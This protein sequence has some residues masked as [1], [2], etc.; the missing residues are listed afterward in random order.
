MHSPKYNT[1]YNTYQIKH[2]FLSF[3]PLIIFVKIKFFIKIR[4]L[5]I[6]LNIVK[7]YICF[8]LMNMLY[9]FLGSII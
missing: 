8:E 1:R 9:F 2:L 5:M 4:S 3:F 7:N 6:T